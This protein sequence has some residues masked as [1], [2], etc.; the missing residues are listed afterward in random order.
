MQTMKL[1]ALILTVSP[2]LYDL[3]RKEELDSEV[4]VTDIQALNREDISEIIEQAIQQHH[5]APYH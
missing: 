3:L 2:D 5:R 4:L 1:S